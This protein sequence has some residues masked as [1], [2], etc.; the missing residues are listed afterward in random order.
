[1]PI[2]Q[3][4]FFSFYR[5]ELVFNNKGVFVNFDDKKTTNL[6]E[7]LNKI[8]A[9]QTVDNGTKNVVAMGR[10]KKYLGSFWRTLKMLLINREV[11]LDLT[12]YASC[13]IFFD[14]LY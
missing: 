14:P 10:K 12:W 9:G 1:M 6:F 7:N 13:V 5:D 3:V 4:V 2:H 11:T 8:A